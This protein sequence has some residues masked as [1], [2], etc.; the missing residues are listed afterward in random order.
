MKNFEDRFI[1][2]KEVCHITGVS[3][4]T[5]WRWEKSGHFPSRIILYGSIAVWKFSEVMDWWHRQSSA[6]A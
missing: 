6:A 4:S 5:I 1:R 2:E 3:R